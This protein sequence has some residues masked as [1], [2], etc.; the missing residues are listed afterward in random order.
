[1]KHTQTKGDDAMVNILKITRSTAMEFIFTISGN[2]AE[3][4]LL[5]KVHY[6][7]LLPVARV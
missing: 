7:N 6:R 5:A 3:G 2:L 1:M 4:A